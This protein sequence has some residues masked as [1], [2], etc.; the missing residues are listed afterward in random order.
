MDCTD[1]MCTC[2]RRKMPGFPQTGAIVPEGL[3]NPYY[4]EL[5]GSQ[6]SSISP[7][8]FGFFTIAVVSAAVPG[9]ST[10]VPAPSVGALTSVPILTSLPCRC[11]RTHASASI[12]HRAH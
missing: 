12:Q 3:T 5:W 4:G 7:I 8:F 6:F 1:A 11:A 10:S 9:S 2:V